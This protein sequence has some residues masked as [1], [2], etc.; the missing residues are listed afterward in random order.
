MLCITTEAALS[1]KCS[2]LLM[3][4]INHYENYRMKSLHMPLHPVANDAVLRDN[5]I[6]VFPLPQLN[7]TT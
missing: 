1:K 6:I 7:L 4:A 5:S 3:A 2:W